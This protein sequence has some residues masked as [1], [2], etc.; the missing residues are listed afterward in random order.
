M[1][2]QTHACA[3]SNA[4]SIEGP[5]VRMEGTNREY[6]RPHAQSLQ[7]SISSSAADLGGGEE[8]VPRRKNKGWPT[9]AGVVQQV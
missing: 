3:F 4:C 1:Q 8:W 9:Y 7:V 2:K 5:R 6:C